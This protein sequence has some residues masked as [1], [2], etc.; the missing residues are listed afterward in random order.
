MN[1]ILVIIFTVTLSILCYGE[2]RAQ[3]IN[4][5]GTVTE[6]GTGIPLP[7][8]NVVEKGTDHGTSTDFDGNYTINVESGKVLVF[9]FLGFVSQEVTIENQT[10]LDIELV[11]SAEALGEIVITALG[12][13]REE[14][15]LTSAQ[16]A[17]SGEEI[18][19]TKQINFVNSLSGK[20]SGL[21]IKR[22]AA[23]AGGSS[24]IVLRGNKSIEGVS[25]PLFVIDG[26]P[27][28]NS[29]PGG[30]SNSPFDSRD[31]GD[32]LS[33]I[34]SDDIESVTVLKGAN[35]AALYG[36]Q[37][38]NGVIL[39][40][41]KAG[42]AGKLSGTVS[43]S[44]EFQ[45]V[46]A[47]P[48]MQFRYGQKN[49]ES[50]ESWA[51]QRGDYN[52][53]FVKNFFDTGVNLTNSISLSGGSE[54]STS[55]L[56]FANTSSDGVIPENTYLRNNLTFKQTNRFFD[57]KLQ[58]SS[59]VM[60][61]EE[62]IK[63]RAS[64]GYYFNPIT[65][66]Y[67]FPRSMDFNS[68]KDYEV[69]NPDRNIMT[70]NWFVDSDLQQNPYWILHNNKNHNNKKRLIANVA[71]TYDINDKMNV[72]VR[73]NYDYM[74]GKWE[75]KI[76]AGTV[77][78]LS[79]ANGRYR[80]SD[81]TDSKLYGDAIFTYS[82]TFG[83]WSL[84][85]VAGASIE[86]T[87][88]GDGIE[89]HSEDLKYVNIFTLQNFSDNS[90]IEQ[91][92]NSKL[93][94]QGVFGSVQLGFQ[95]KLFLDLSGRNDWSSSLAFT[96]NLSYF[97]PAIGFSALLGDIVEL[98]DF[99][100]FAKL[101]GSYSVVS[102]EVPAFYTN[103]LNTID[104]NGI[105]INTEKP[106]EELKPEDQYSLELGTDLR[107]FSGRLNLDFTYYRID[108]KN[109]FIPLDAPSGSGYSKYFVNA[110]H[111]RNSG[112]ELALRSSIIQNTDFGWNTTLNY[113]VNRNKI[114]ALHPELKGRYQL[115]N[116]EGYASFI[117]E[118][119]HFSDIYVYKFARDDQGRI[120]IKD[121]GEPQGTS[122][123]E[124]IGQADPDFIFGWNNTFN[125]KNWR[126]SFLI[127]AKVG[128]KIVSGTE[129]QLDAFGVS[130]R[131]ARA[132]DVGSYTIN[133]VDASGNAI[134][135]VDPETFFKAV[136]GR[137][138]ILENYV[139]NA[140]NIRFSELA[141]AY[142]HDFEGDIFF[143]SASLSFIANNLFF[144]YKKAPFDPEVAFNPG[145]TFQ[146]FN[147]FSIPPVRSYGIN[148]NIKF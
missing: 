105:K 69:Y 18:S 88:V 71:V 14:R 4:L 12:I 118:G 148:L 137:D 114:I 94:K 135:S 72:Q 145:N 1:R 121:N 112:Y 98:P 107:F 147:L 102:T 39:I 2:L 27:M 113:S 128:G 64:S 28:L 29:S 7:G 38:A 77:G 45:N 74:R 85:V 86:R 54:N 17:V 90:L 108:N 61:A 125:Y 67:L 9:S 91:T 109:Q 60:L 23:G 42:R 111:I 13:K 32:G 73:G 144:I 134:T 34:N 70:Q 129:A 49:N 80:M 142:T 41:T 47:L 124:R 96:D 63:N 100:S 25:Q 131:S 6:Q 84:D 127:D 3:E 83:D 133:G 146:G 35:S 36:S 136:G 103:P 57:D 87:T 30:S 16:Q 24:K 115:S 92:I 43:S 52:K 59:R 132:R 46:M 89:A 139:Y 48:K 37:G 110:G 75:Q 76:K 126:L 66:L 19:K 117:T 26:I 51:T 130:E 44:A 21:Q 140:T 93:L 58:I 141:I 79:P 97:Y 65:G 53:N 31:N 138:G 82:D 122:E 20:T 40:T 81:L 8:V 120:L 68:F 55:Y 62:N 33:Q 101:R 50:S 10:I 99:I 95:N 123:T 22:S 106:F 78:V 143:K 104:A 56:S 11:E 116:S 5:S 119:G 15:T